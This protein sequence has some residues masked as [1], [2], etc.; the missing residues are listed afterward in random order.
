MQLLE[1]RD[2]LKLLVIAGAGSALDPT[3][4]FG[5]DAKSSRTPGSYAAGRIPNEYSL[6]L[7]GEKEALRQAPSVSAIA[8]GGL[9]A[10][11]GSHSSRM[12]AGDLLEGWR[13]L[14]IVGMNGVETAVFEKHVTHRGA[15]VYVTQ[16]EGLIAYIPKQIGDLSKIRPRPTNTS[17]GVRLERA[18]HYIPRPD[19]AGLY[20]LNSSDDPSYENVAAL[21]AEYIGWTLVANEQGGPKT[22]LY[23]DAAGTSREISGKPSGE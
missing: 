12:R 8:E 10:K 16:G 6:F 14:T 3:L 15:I 4:S 18:P 20:I 1:R 23:L 2:F 13:L 17:D 5:L 22:S 9:V 11:L 19:A 21:G 7:A